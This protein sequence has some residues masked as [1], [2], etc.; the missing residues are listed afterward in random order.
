MR[1]N[2]V[3]ERERY[4]EQ[5]SRQLTIAVV[6]LPIQQNLFLHPIRHLSCRQQA[7]VASS[8]CNGGGVHQHSSSAVF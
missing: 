6:T 2:Q 1:C 5:I 7:A 3:H 4:T 8:T